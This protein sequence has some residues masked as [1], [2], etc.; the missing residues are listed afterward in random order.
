MSTD[1]VLDRIVCGAEDFFDPVLIIAAHPDDEV[2]GM[3]ARLEKLRN[4]VVVYVTDGAPKDYSFAYEAGFPSRQAYGRAR[5]NEARESLDIAGLSSK[6]SLCMGYYDQDLSLNMVGLILKIKELFRTVQP[7][8]VFTHS[9]EGGHPDH[10]TVA[11]SV[12]CARRL[13]RQSPLHCEFT[14][15]HNQ[16]GYM[17]TGH[18]LSYRTRMFR[19]RVLNRGE[20]EHKERMRNCFRTQKRML[21]RF[22]FDSELYRSAP[23]YNF[24]SPPHKGVLFYE[25]FD[26]GVTGRQWRALADDA[27][28]LLRIRG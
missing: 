18:F 11:F 22:S 2:I 14:S 3:G 28:R 23:R 16:K 6:N 1:N 15:Y 8:A 4:A 19:K 12:A 13:S 7:L 25:M 20:K 21:E 27:K 17:R 5:L 9:Y 26:W 10:D 24:S